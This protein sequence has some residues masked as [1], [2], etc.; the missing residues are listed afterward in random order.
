MLRYARMGG[1]FFLVDGTALAYRSHFAFIN[2]PL[3]NAKGQE[4]S[5]T[6]GYVR[7]LLDI[8]NK[9][10]PDCVVVAFDVSRDTFRKK[11]YPEYKATREKRRGR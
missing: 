5:A 10:S 2:N 7:A 4:T 8:L 6:F 1:T 11:M 9:E 3:T